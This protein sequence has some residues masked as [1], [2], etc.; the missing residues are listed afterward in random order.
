MAL[1]KPIASR[2]GGTESNPAEE[3]PD[4]IFL[5]LDGEGRAAQ[6]DVSWI[7]E[8]YNRGALENYS[9][10]YIAVV[11][12]KILGHGKDLNKLRNEVSTATGIAQSRIVT[13]LIDFSDW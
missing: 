5:Q 6:A 13:S 7:D 9:G 4:E 3:L 11:A 1:N 10:E 2:S 12:K 8:E